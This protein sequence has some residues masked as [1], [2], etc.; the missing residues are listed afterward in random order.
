MLFIRGIFFK[1]ETSLMNIRKGLLF[2]NLIV[3][4][5][6][7][8]PCISL[9]N[10]WGISFEFGTPVPPDNLNEFNGGSI[11][12]GLG[13]HLPISLWSGH[14]QTWAEYAWYKFKASSSGY[15]IGDH[16]DPD[17]KWG[18]D[19]G[20][21]TGMAGLKIYSFNEN[22][23]FNPFA[24]LK[25]GFMHRSKD[26]FRTTRLEH[27]YYEQNYRIGPAAALG[28]GLRIVSG[29]HVSFEMDYSH[30]IGYTRPDRTSF[31]L[32]RWRLALK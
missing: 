5:N 16:V 12:A 19:A 1:R 20:I 10:G 26:I 22:R 28:L 29:N 32:M 23:K 8:S 27:A 25:F 18:K 24:M 9:A 3:G 7:L 2:L 31:S 6:S 17:A 14:Q 15:G 13:I 11:M 30:I 21:T 4:L